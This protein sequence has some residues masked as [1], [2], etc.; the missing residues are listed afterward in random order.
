MPLRCLTWNHRNAPVAL[1][2]SLHIEEAAICGVL[3]ALRADI[4]L[5]ECAL[6]CTCHRTELYFVPPAGVAAPDDTLAQRT[7]ALLVQ[8]AGAAVPPESAAL[9]RGDAAVRHLFRVASGLES[10][11]IGE[12]QILGQVKAA[13]RLACEAGCNGFYTNACFHRAFRA[14]KR[15]RAQTR[16]G[17]AGI[18]AADVA[19]AHAERAL[20]GLAAKRVLVAG[21]GEIADLLLRALADRRPARVSVARRSPG[22]ACAVPGIAVICE[23]P[24]DAIGRAAAEHDVLFSATASPGYVLTPAMLAE[25][26]A[27]HALAIYDLALPRDVDP[28]VAALPGVVL[29]HLDTLAVT[30][31]EGVAEEDIRAAEA[32]VDRAMED[33]RAWRRELAAVPSIRRLIAI[34]ESVRQAELEKIA[35]ALA[36]PERERM[37]RVTHRMTQRILK[38]IADELKRIARDAP[39]AGPP[40]R[41]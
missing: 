6:L 20:G 40:P 41:A 7:A 5:E 15:V 27:G 17:A 24:L 23:V 10:L 14:G 2:E 34:S 8:I 3:R 16:L 39:D 36:G 28:A 26:P 30:A 9:L 33:Y 21:G 19:V 35:A 1:R 25:W 4:P 38:A 11:A 13:Y 18:S 12:S 29:H 37:E 22:R 32:I 31:P